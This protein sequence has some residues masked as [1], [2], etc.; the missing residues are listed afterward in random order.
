MTLRSRKEDAKEPRSHEVTY[1][2][3]EKEKGVENKEVQKKEN[4]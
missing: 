4:E 3:S 1:R 2:R